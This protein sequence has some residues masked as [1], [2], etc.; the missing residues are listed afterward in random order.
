[1][2]FQ[3][4]IITSL[5]KVTT[6]KLYLEIQRFHLKAVVLR[7]LT[8]LSMCCTC[9][10]FHL[11][12]FILSTYPNKIT[13]TNKPTTV[14]YSTVSLFLCQELMKGQ[15]GLAWRGD[16]SHPEGLK[17]HTVY[18]LS[19]HTPAQKSLTKDLCTP[20]EATRDFRAVRSEI[21]E[22]DSGMLSVE[23]SQSPVLTTAGEV[24]VK[25][26][27]SLLEETSI[28]TT[29]TRAPSQVSVTA[30]EQAWA[31][32]PPTSTFRLQHQDDTEG[33]SPAAALVSKKLI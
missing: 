19:T 27:T 26:S 2:S 14:I 22:V 3:Q 30:A 9:T 20:S 23:T 5:R 15:R 32:E 4:F 8:L 28:T 18:T 21:S 17:T 29:Q 12:L 6:L 25:S 11:C 33:L 31:S 1:M 16:D 24:L 13:N 7:C 10:L